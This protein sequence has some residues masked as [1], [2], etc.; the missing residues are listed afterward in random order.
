MLKDMVLTPTSSFTH[1]E[2]EEVSE[3][4]EVQRAWKEIDEMW[5]E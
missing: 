3:D 1:V 4:D 2:G 5:D